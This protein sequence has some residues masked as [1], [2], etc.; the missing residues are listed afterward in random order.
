MLLHLTL[1]AQWTPEEKQRIIEERIEYIAQ[2]LEAE[3]SDFTTLFDNLDALLDDPIDLN[4]ADLDELQSSLLFNE[5]QIAGIMAHRKKYGKFLAIYELK[6]VHGF[7]PSNIQ[8][9]LPFVTV[10]TKE[11][12]STFKAKWLLKGRHSILIRHQRV[13]EESIAFSDPDSISSANSRYLGDPNRIYAR[14]RYQAGK[15]LSLGITGEKDPGEEF[16]SG[17]QSKGFDYYSAHAAISNIGPI[18]TFVVGDYQAQFGQGLALWTGFGF[19]KSSQ[20][21]LNTRRF[22]RGFV[23]YT[24]VDENNFMRGVAATFKIK[25]LEASIF[26]SAK[27]LDANLDTTLSSDL[28]ESTFT[29]LQQTGFHRTQGEVFDKDAVQ[30]KVY[31]ANLSYRF[32]N[33]RLGMTGFQSELEGDFDPDLQLYNQFNQQDASNQVLSGNYEWAASFFQL[34]GEYAVS[35]NGA[36]AQLHGI[37]LN[38][39]ELIKLN[40]LYRNKEAEFQNLYANSFGERS[41]SSNEIGWYHGIEILPF[42]DLS[43]QAYLDLYK[44]PWMSFRTDKPGNG[45]EASIF[46]RYRVDRKLELSALYRTENRDR[47]DN[48]EELRVQQIVREQLDQ[49]RLQLDY[50]INSSVSVRTRAEYRRYTLGSNPLEEAYMLYQDLAYNH[51]NGKWNLRMRYALFNTDSYNSRIYAYEN[52]MRYQFSVPAYFGEGSRYY[53]L[54]NFKP[55]R[56]MTLSFRIARTFRIDDALIGSGQDAIQGPYKTEIK[57]QLHYR[58]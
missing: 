28:A 27:K 44:F 39:R 13:L 51:R 57:S 53:L 56:G 55:I 52:D 24:S 35:E 15:N 1:S 33:L 41:V 31:G 18:K 32:K 22:A 7:N 8:F 58:F 34:Y 26:Y 4:S 49:Y 54:L 19:R 38:A 17:D 30:E 42:Q 3:S 36:S 43:I 50:D 46:A 10:G 47:N 14:W 29:S 20:Q 25:S 11:R 9:A 48:V 16:F 5:I 37:T 45:Q 40:I 12:A 21:A 23:P 6:Y 2:D